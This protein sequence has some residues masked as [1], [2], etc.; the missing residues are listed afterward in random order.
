MV[1]RLFNI[2]EDISIDQLGK[3]TDLF[4][5]VE[6]ACDDQDIVVTTSLCCMNV[7]ASSR[8]VR[9]ITSI[10]TDGFHLAQ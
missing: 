6:P 8:F 4:I 1:Q 5:I 7:H 2:I 10:F 9:A 3:I